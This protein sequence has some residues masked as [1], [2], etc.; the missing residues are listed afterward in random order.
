MLGAIIFLKSPN[1]AWD[2]AG[3]EDSPWVTTLRCPV[4]ARVKLAISSADVSGKRRLLAT[5]SQRGCSS[6]IPSGRSG[7]PFEAGENAWLYQRTLSGFS[8]SI[9]IR[10]PTLYTSCMKKTFIIVGIII[11]GILL[12]ASSYNGLVTK[13]QEVEKQWGNVQT[14]YQRRTDLV[15]NLVNTVKGAAN[16]EQQ[17][18]TQVVEARASATQVKVDA[19]DLT[20]ENLAKF[21]AA[22]NNLSGALGRLLA[23]SENYPQLQATQA[24]R[25]LQVQLEGTENR[26]AVSRKDFNAAV[27]S[28]NTTVK[29]FPTV[30]V[31]ALFGYKEK[32][33][34]AAA[35]S[36]Q[37][38]P[39]VNFEPTA[40]APTAPQTPVTQ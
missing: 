18:L 29:R 40:P 19:G 39:V 22:Q 25:D 35:D 14:D 26:I 6:Q 10:T 36:A 17:T 30:M 3:K 13:N 7:E 5:S 20:P 9:C 8:F 24:F 1:I 33:Y 16:F 28:Y 38:A 21:Q 15:G 11:V 27:L 31:A 23:I 12:I 4:S 32:G 37:T 2:I 34:F